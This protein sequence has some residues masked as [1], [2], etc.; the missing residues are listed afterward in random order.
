M[1]VAEYHSIGLDFYKSVTVFLLM[2]LACSSHAQNVDTLVRFSGQLSSFSETAKKISIV[3]NNEICIKS[4][5]NNTI[6][7]NDDFCIPNTE[8]IPSSSAWSPDGNKLAVIYRSE[9]SIDEYFS[10]LVVEAGSFQQ[11]ILSKLPN[12]FS[13]VKSTVIK[14]WVDERSL[15]LVSACGSSCNQIRLIDQTGTLNTEDVISTDHGYLWNNVLQ[16]IIGVDRT[17]K[18]FASSIDKSQLSNTEINTSYHFEGCLGS[19]SWYSNESKMYWYRFEETINDSR[20]IFSEH[21]C[22]MGLTFQLGTNKNIL[23]DDDFILISSA[24]I[25]SPISANNNK[26]LIASI[27]SEDNS[28]YL[29]IHTLPQ[30]EV[31]FKDLLS[32]YEPGNPEIQVNYKYF[33]PIWSPGDSYI[34]IPKSSKSGGAIVFNLTS[35]RKEFS[36]LNEPVGKSG[37]FWIDSNLLIA[38]D[39]EFITI[40]EVQ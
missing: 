40:L 35:Q 6:N 2:F 15:L 29:V 1:K 17:G 14:T 19:D 26:S 21:L 9:N 20:V 28:Y 5:S 39:L 34:L 32:N 4:F 8:Y 7:T 27:L 25:G 12:V 33:T 38:V 23:I 10:L 30:L 37:F 3:V 13:Q 16:Y 22:D 31:V 24:Q 18:V 11:I 36:E